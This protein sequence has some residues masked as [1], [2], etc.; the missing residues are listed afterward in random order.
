MS[1]TTCSCFLLTFLSW[2]VQGQGSLFCNSSEVQ[3]T[4]A[5]FWSR[6][7]QNSLHWHLAGAG[8]NQRRPTFVADALTVWRQ[9]LLADFVLQGQEPL[10]VT[11]RNRL[12]TVDLLEFVIRLWVF[13]FLCPSRPYPVLQKDDSWYATPGDCPGICFSLFCCMQKQQLMLCKKILA[14][15]SNWKN[16]DSAFS[17]QCAVTATMERVAGEICKRGFEVELLFSQNWNRC[18]TLDKQTS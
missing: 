13:L 10:G 9:I 5:F 7:P 1:W 17:I 2:V 4:Y 18:R 14:F 16:V 15:Q 8:S 12:A 3:Q 6:F 11:S